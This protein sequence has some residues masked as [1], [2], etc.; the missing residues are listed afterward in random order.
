MS[1]RLHHISLT[2]SDLK[3][4]ME[5]YRLQGFMVQQCYSDEQC[6]IVLMA[7]EA[8]HIELFC[9]SDS[10]TQQQNSSDFLKK[11]GITHFALHVSSLQQTRSQLQS[12]GYQCGEII[13]ARLGKFRYFFTSDP[14]GNHVE[15]IEDIQ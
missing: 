14:D 4:S 7:G 11:K 12:C 1:G 13:T 5:F 6:Q 15:F 10:V 3:K 9:F 2:C 8:G